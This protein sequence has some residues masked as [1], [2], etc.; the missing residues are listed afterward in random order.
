MTKISYSSILQYP[1]KKESLVFFTVRS[2]GNTA[3]VST[4]QTVKTKMW[5][6]QL[7]RC[8]TSKEMFTD[9]ENREA[10]KI[11]KQLDK[12]EDFIITRLN[13]W[14]EQ[15]RYLTDPKEFKDIVTHYANMFFRGIEEEEKKQ[16]QKAT[17]WMLANINSDRID[18]HSGRFVAERTKKAQSTVIHR[19]Q[20]FLSDNHLE[21]TFKTF[22]DADFANKYMKWCY[23]KKNYK[24]NTIY[25]TYEILKAQL[26]AAKKSGFNID[27]TYYKELRGKCKD[28]DNIYLTEREIEAIYKLDIPHLKKEGLIDEKS[29]MEQT[30]DLF[31]V[32]CYTGLRRSDLNKLNDGIWNLSEDKNTVSIVA[33]KTKKRVVIPLHPY[34][35][36]IYYK[37]NGILPKL[38]DKYNTNVHLKNLARLAGINE[39]VSKTENRGGKVT[40][41]KHQKYDLVSFHTARRSFA[42]NMVLKGVPTLA[43][44]QLTG[45]TNEQTF[46]KYVKVTPEQ[47]AKL[48]GFS[49]IV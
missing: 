23:E 40:T 20:S 9:R 45:H 5:N 30:R 19:L 38:G 31:I 14:G 46:R 16:N 1:K 39:I 44:R 13:G 36:A 10:R 33:E 28:V 37:Y 4:R 11:N 34:V 25:V 21:D 41:L 2:N 12:I 22:A 48:F 32:G 3:K 43:I 15:S 49:P 26:N 27:D 35:R 6:K 7:H 24:E 17:E 47:Y 29:T 42:T 8:I 18:I